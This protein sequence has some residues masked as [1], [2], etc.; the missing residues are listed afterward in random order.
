MKKLWTVVGLS[1]VAAVAMA[2]SA[3]A[4]EKSDKGAD[5]PKP[6]QITGE[7]CAISAD[8]ITVK[9][10]KEG[11]VKIAMTPKTTFGTKAEP[12]K[13]DDFKVGDKVVV[14]F[15]EDGDKKCAT[16]VRVP[17]PPKKKDATK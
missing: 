7:V 4:A 10:K 12:K 9:S 6:K 16:S 13:C 8:C 14:F 1:L 15:K 11:E 17:A 3:S 2:V 5:K